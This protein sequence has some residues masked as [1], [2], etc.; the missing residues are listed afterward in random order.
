VDCTE[1]LS[2][3]AGAPS[4]HRAVFG[5]TQSFAG[6]QLLRVTVASKDTGLANSTGIGFWSAQATD[7]NQ[8]AE[9][10]G[11]FVPKA[12]FKA[13]GAATLKNGA[14]ATL[15]EFVGVANCP[16]GEGVA[17]SRLFKPYMQFE[18]AADGRLFRNW[19]IAENY[20]ISPTITSFDRSADVLQQ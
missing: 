19:D 20:R 8:A 10:S 14:P 11:R 5:A 18:G 4:L 16:A 13:L 3:T 1:A 17:L 15:H 9:N 2:Q 6:C 7:G 12:R